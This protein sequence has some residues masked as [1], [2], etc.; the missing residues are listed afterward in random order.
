MSASKF[1]P[2]NPPAGK[3]K[4][5]AQVNR[6]GAT[7]FFV[8]TLQIVEVRR[9]AR[10]KLDDRMVLMKVRTFKPADLAKHLENAAKC[11]PVFP[12]IDVAKV[13]CGHLRQRKSNPAQRQTKNAP[14]M[15]KCKQLTQG[16]AAKILGVTREHLNRVLNGARES[17]SLVRRYRALKTGGAK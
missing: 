6:P 15:K 1:F 11:F 8:E 17:K 3:V 2:G 10:G 5:L 14:Q 9:T 13:K 7:K 16:Q 12:G 4:K